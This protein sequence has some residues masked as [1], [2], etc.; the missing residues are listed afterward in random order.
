LKRPA[1]VL[2]FVCQLRFE[3]APPGIQDGLGHLGFH[4]LF[5]AHI[6]NYYRLILTDHPCAELVQR[7][8]ALP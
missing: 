6:A 4:E 3:H 7:V 5:A 2:A 8:L 1:S